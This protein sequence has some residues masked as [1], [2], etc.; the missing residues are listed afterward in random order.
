MLLAKGRGQR[1]SSTVATNRGFARPLAPTQ[2]SP[3]SGHDA[4]GE[5]SVAAH[6]EWKQ[7]T[8]SLAHQPATLRQ[9]RFVLAVAA[10]QF[11]ACFAIAP[12]PASVPRIDGF[13][14]AILAIVFIADLFT[15]VLLFNQSSLIASRALLVLANGYLFSALIVIPHALTFPGAFAPKGLLGA[16]AQSSGWLNVFWNLG[17]I[18]AVA[19]YA[20]LKDEDHRNDAIPPSTL[21]AFC[22]SAAI[23]L[24]LICVLT[25]AV[26]AGDRFMPSMF[27]D[28]LNY[29]PLVHYAAGTIVLLS[30]VAL[31]L[32]WTRLTSV[33]D[34]WVM[35][36]I[37]M[38]IT[39]KTLVAFGMTTRFSVG[40]YVSRALA[41]AV[42]MAV[43]IALLSKLMRLHATL[44]RSQHQQRTLNAELD[45]RVKNVLATVS[46]IIAQTPN[47]HS[48][49][50]DY[51]AGLDQR[52][53]SLART[54]ELLSNSQWGGV[55]LADIA[56]RELAP[57]AT[58][59]AEIGGPDVTLKADA[60]Q[61]MG[62]VLHELA[63]NAAKYGAF[64]RPG[65]R[66]SL[67][68]WWLQNGT[69]GRLAIEW[70]ELGGPHVSKPSHFGY[71]TSTIRELIPFELGGTVDLA[72]ASSGLRCQ[73][74]IP[75]DWVRG[76]LGHATLDEI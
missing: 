48:K 31:L 69:C 20:W 55:S 19:G 30:V 51:A 35:A 59:N 22:W 54:H 15:A 14:P 42:S 62:M 5:T 3:L 60:A 46:A 74:E 73:L 66:L 67:R 4:D 71:G 63:T 2:E 53:R 36:A 58:D 34:L 21:S 56:R 9:R 13:I 45:H 65:G 49:Q 43:L 24:G 61:A 1:P 29:T 39:E 41:V 23:Q 25:V 52:I 68:W 27:L 11:V 12:L 26:T 40:W 38:L 76:T 33:L 47:S 10:L 72:F 18:V 8:I 64:A 75:A 44:L 57:Y 50:A 28:D 7:P 17:F 70:Q 6:L 37:C 32:L 16:S